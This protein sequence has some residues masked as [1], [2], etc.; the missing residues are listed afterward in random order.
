MIFWQNHKN[1]NKSELKK[2]RVQHCFHWSQ[3]QTLLLFSGMQVLKFWFHT[4][5]K[6]YVVQIKQI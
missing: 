2:W 3:W 5:N 6:Q 4:Q 1:E